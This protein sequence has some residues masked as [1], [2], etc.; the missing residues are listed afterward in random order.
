MHPRITE[1]DLLSV[2]PLADPAIIKGLLKH[3]NDIL[4][5][6]GIDTP[7]RI[8]H[9]LAQ[10][11]HETAGFNTMVEYGSRAYFIKRYGHRRDLGNS[12]KL[13]GWLF[14]GRGIFQLTGR[15]NYR[16]YGHKI[17][18]PLEAKPN[19]AADP[20]ISLR[21]AG[22]YWRSHKLNELADRGKFE[23][24]TRRINGGTNGI[25]DRRRYLKRAWQRF[26]EGPLPLDAGIGNV[27]DEG[28]SGPG[29][30]ALQQRLSALG[31]HLGA[32]DGYFGARSPGWRLFG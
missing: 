14:H 21:I 15:D 12:S 7:A 16:R 32:I 11:A 18:V 26:G 3:I 19:L 29:V 25:E 9:F 1:A 4:P 28:D 6:Y 17:G 13:D 8:S 22:E 2:A 5:Q 31:Y 20:I 10:A 23:T 24:I 30:R 27:L